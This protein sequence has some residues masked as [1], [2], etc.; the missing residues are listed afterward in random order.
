ML[1]VVFE[2]LPAERLPLGGGFT[3]TFLFQDNS[4]DLGAF[5]TLKSDTADVEELLLSLLTSLQS[6]S[7][8]EA[9]T[10]QS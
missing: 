3:T 4:D 7:S 8:L 10:P 2:L 9:T 5:K 6:W 1:T